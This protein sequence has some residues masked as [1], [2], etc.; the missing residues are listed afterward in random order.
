MTASRLVAFLHHSYVPARIAGD[1]FLVLAEGSG[2][3]TTPSSWPSR[4]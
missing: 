2:A 3:W 4:S 1:E